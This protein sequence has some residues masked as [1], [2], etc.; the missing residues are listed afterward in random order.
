ML[1][2]WNVWN[3]KAAIII[4]IM[5]HFSEA[6]WSSWSGGCSVTCGVGTQSKTRVCLNDGGEQ[7]DSSLCNGLSEE[8]GLCFRPPC[9]SN[10]ALII[11]YI[12]RCREIFMVSTAIS[13]VRRSWWQCPYMYTNYEVNY[14]RPN[15]CL[16]DSY[17]IEDRTKQQPQYFS[18]NECDTLQNA[19]SKLFETEITFSALHFRH[20]N[21]FTLFPLYGEKQNVYYI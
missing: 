9:P 6:E 11:T 12:H 16:F 18:P 21:P 8:R 13:L 5:N 3:I 20:A 17:E 7:V 14:P 4:W 15:S 1:S 19:F 10:W 2:E